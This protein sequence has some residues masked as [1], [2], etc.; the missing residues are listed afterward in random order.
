MERIRNWYK[1]NITPVL[2]CLRMNRKHI[3]YA[4]LILG[5]FLFALNDIQIVWS[6]SRVLENNAAEGETVSFKVLMVSDENGIKTGAEVESAKV[7]ATV[8]KQD[9]AKKIIVFKY[10]AKKNERKKQGHRQPFTA[11]K[12]EK[13]EL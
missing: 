2:P 8:V 13:I 5:L 10:K 1:I 12:V 4:V 6:V 9:K 11:V 7:T 3:L